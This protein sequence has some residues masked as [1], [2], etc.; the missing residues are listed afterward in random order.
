MTYN[1][2]FKLT[3]NLFDV[4]PNLVCHE[5]RHLPP[6]HLRIRVGVGND[7][8]ANQHR[9][10]NT[11]QFWLFAFA[12]HWCDFESIIVDIGVGCG[13]YAHH[14]RDFYFR[15]QRFNG[16]YIGIDIDEEALSWCREHFDEEMF[17]FYHS[18]DR[19]TSYNRDVGSDHAYILPVDNDE[20]DFVFS[21][22]LFTHLLEKEMNNY[23]AESF[24]ALKPGGIMAHSVF[25]TDYPPP[26]YGDRHTFRHR[27][28]HAHIE[29]PRQ[30]EAAVAY[31]KDYLFERAAR[32]GF[33]EVDMLHGEGSW[34]PLLV[35]RK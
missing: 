15:G 14:L 11:Y 6:N 4:L 7:L 10:H 30:P 3:V 26:T 35:G 18:T 34:Q 24:R 22:S 8:I 9:Y 29:S 20:A 33:R 31:A 1:P 16:K 13:R 28:G 12:K 2:F 19:S 21:T 23:L 27:L 25:C 17:S 32:V 5:F